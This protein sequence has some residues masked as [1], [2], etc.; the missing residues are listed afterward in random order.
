MD[1]PS[2]RSK[3]SSF[4][5]HSIEEAKTPKKS[6]EGNWFLTFLKLLIGDGVVGFKHVSSDTFRGFTGCFDTILNDSNSEF[7]TWFRSEPQSKGA[8]CLDVDIFK[9]TVKSWH[10]G[11]G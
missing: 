2:K 6:T 9:N 7:V 11:N 8:V 1:I 4:E 10:E 5:N 3:L